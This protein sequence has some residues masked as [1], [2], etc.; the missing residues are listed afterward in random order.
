VATLEGNIFLARQGGRLL[1]HNDEQHD[2]NIYR[3]NVYWSE[4]APDSLVFPGG[5]KLDKWRAREPEALVA[6][7][8]FVNAAAGDFRPD[9]QSPAIAHGFVSVDWSKAGRLTKGSRT[10]GLPPVARVYPPA[11]SAQQMESK[12]VAVDEGFEVYAKGQT[13]TDRWPWSVYVADG[14]AQSVTVTDETAAAGR[15]SL[16]FVDSPQGYAYQPHAVIKA[17][18]SSGLVRNSFDLRVEPG[19]RLVWE[20][21]DWQ[22]ELKTGPQLTVNPDGALLAN[23]KKLVT[24]PHSQ[25]V[26]LEIVCGV[27]AQANGIYA[28]T[29]TLPGENA[30]RRFELLKYPAG[31][32]VL[33][34]TGFAS[35]SDPKGVYYVDNLRLAKSN[36]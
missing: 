30:P 5:V 9:P 6:D 22:E 27:G 35:Y 25:W 11:P 28:V 8:R 17:R 32:Q 13:W 16:K 24:V 14:S 15:L 23:G 1:I 2:K 21:R 19:T 4:E 33:T 7:P 31:F 36:E 10:A 34:W 29:V 26:H 3:R 20:W 18:Y 12:T